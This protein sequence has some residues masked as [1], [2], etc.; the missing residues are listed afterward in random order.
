MSEMNDKT[1]TGEAAG[2]CGNCGVDEPQH[3]YWCKRYKAVGD[4]RPDT[5]EATAKCGRC[6]H[7][8]HTNRVCRAESGFDL[9]CDCIEP[10]WPGPICPGYTGEAAAP[11]AEKWPC[12]H[13]KRGVAG[14]PRGHAC[15]R[16]FYQEAMDAE[17][18]AGDEK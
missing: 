3:T 4:Y 13:E 17:I 11:A 8:T 1:N 7:V 5:G 15:D 10:E 9:M 18:A 2:R 6:G 12:G 16:E 14:M